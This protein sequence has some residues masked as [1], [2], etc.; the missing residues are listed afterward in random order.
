V[1]FTR[2]LRILQEDRYWAATSPDAPG[3]IS[4]HGVQVG[5]PDWS[6]RSRTL[7]FTLAHPSGTELVHVMTNSGPRG[8]DFAL[9]APDGGE[10]WELV[11]DTSRPSPADIGEPGVALP[12]TAAT[13]RVAPFSVVVLTCRPA[14]R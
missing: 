5:R 8:L 9:P 10:P 4:W 12:V 11:I 6:A 13:L 2:G 7:A 14:A 3:D 1:A